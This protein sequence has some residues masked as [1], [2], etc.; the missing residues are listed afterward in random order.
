[1]AHNT[2]NQQHY[3]NSKLPFTIIKEWVDKDFCNRSC[4]VIF[5]KELRDGGKYTNT[6]TIIVKDMS[7]GFHY[8]IKE[9]NKYRK[10]AKEYA[11]IRILERCPNIINEHNLPSKNKKEF[12][13]REPFGNLYDRYKR[14]GR[15][16]FDE[17]EICKE[18]YTNTNGD[19]FDDDE[20]PSYE[21]EEWNKLST[22]QKIEILDNQLTTYFFN[23]EYKKLVDDMINYAI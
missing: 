2:F 8:T 6:C 17:Y 23:Y 5:K 19:L 1:M 4:D 22:Q 10:Y 7:N 14:F 9:Y 12:I 20:E 11:A 13:F 16:K 3:G 15:I 18:E 21:K